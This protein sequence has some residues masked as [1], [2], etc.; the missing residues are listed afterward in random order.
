M[1]KVLF[2]LVLV[3]LTFQG[4]YLTT[5]DSGEVGVQVAAGTVSDKPVTEG[6]AWTLMPLTTLDRYNVKA[7]LLEMS[8]ENGNDTP[9]VINDGAVTIITDKGMPIP[10]DVTILYKL[11]DSCAP[12]IRKEF[13]KDVTWD[14]SIIVPNARDIVKD[15][16][17]KDSADIYALNQNREKYA[18]LIKAGLENKANTALK[19]QCI[20]V[21]MVSVKDIH[22]PKEFMDTIMKKNQMEEESRRTELQVKKARAEAEIEIARAEG[23]S[24]AQL[25]LAKSITP[26]MIKWKE[27]ENTS[28]AIQ[29]WDGKL[30]TTNM[31]NAVPFVNVK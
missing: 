17:G 4:C 10:I 18:A 16:I 7:K 11:K 25:A 9:E 24:K 22:I 26:E 20:T 6:L 14:N 23:T 8:G 21:E 28:N 30:P 29:K 12:Y 13:G 15:V 31:S 3:A 19:N 2:S 27:L 5:V 1:K